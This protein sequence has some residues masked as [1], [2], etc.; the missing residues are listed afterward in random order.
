M[1][2]V[3]LKLSRSEFD[4]LS[5]AV[6]DHCGINLHDGKQELVEARLSKHIRQGGFASA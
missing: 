2:D 4:A 1:N 6:Y 3:D 5:S